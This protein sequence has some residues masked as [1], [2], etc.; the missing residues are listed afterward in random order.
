MHRVIA[1]WTA[2]LL[3]CACSTPEE[4]AETRAPLYVD[5]HVP[6]AH[7][8]LPATGSTPAWGVVEMWNV[9]ERWLGNV[10]SYCIAHP[11][12]TYAPYITK[13]ANYTTAIAYEFEVMPGS[14]AGR[15]TAVTTSWQQLAYTP[16]AVVIMYDDPCPTVNAAQWRAAH[17]CSGDWTAMDGG[18]VPTVV[19][20][21]GIAKAGLPYGDYL[22]WTGAA[23]A[24]SWCTANFSD[25]PNV[26]KPAG[27]PNHVVAVDAC[28]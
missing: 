3:T 22:K 24:G 20:G 28:P 25:Y 15:N 27:L 23:G 17:A 13:S 11:T 14:F 8:P 10:D 1:F 16:A 18:G 7:G 19:I 21:N 5:Q 12:P 2:L 6:L 9:G 4:T 26:A